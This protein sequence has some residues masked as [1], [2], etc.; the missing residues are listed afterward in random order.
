MKMKKVYLYGAI[1]LLLIGAAIFFAAFNTD[2]KTYDYAK[3]APGLVTTVDY[4]PIDISSITLPV[5]ATDEDIQHKIAS[6]LASKAS[7][8]ISTTIIPDNYD[9]VSV[10]YYGTD[11]DGKIVT[12]PDTMNPSKPTKVQLG[13]GSKW[14]AVFGDAITQKPK[15]YNTV[16]SGLPDATDI[17]FVTYTVKATD[18]EAEKKVTSE[19]YQ[20]AADAVAKFGDTILSTPIGQEIT[21]GDAYSSVKVDWVART[22]YNS[23]HAHAAG[24][25]MFITVTAKNSSDQTLTYYLHTDGTAENTTVVKKSGTSEDLDSGVLAAILAKTGLKTGDS[26][27]IES[28]AYTGAEILANDT[29]KAGT[30]YND[31]ACK[32]AIE[33]NSTLVPETTYYVKV[34]KHTY[35]VNSVMP[36]DP[37]AD[38][39]N[40]VK[41]ADFTDVTYT[42]PEDSTEKDKDGVELKGKTVTY[43]VIPVGVYNVDLSYTNISGLSAFTDR[44]DASNLKS[45]KT[46]YDTYAT[47]LDALKALS[48]VEV[49]KKAYTA[50]E[51]A[52]KALTKDTG[53]KEEDTTDFL[54]AMTAY[55]QDTDSAEKEAA[56]NQA[57]NDLASRLGDSNKSKLT[58]CKSTYTTLL[59]LVKEAGWSDLENSVKDAALVKGALKDEDITAFC[60]A[61]LAYFPDEQNKKKEI[62][63]YEAYTKF[64]AKLSSE[65]KTKLTEYVSALKTLVTRMR[66][67]DVISASLTTLRHYFTEAELEDLLTKLKA[68]VADEK[69]E[70]LKT[71]YEDA[72]KALED[73]ATDDADLSDADKDKQKAAL[74]SYTDACI[75]AIK[76]GQEAKVDAN[77]LLTAVVADV[78][79]QK[80]DWFTA[81]AKEELN[82]SVR[83]LLNKER[84]TEY[85][86]EVT[87][88]IW[89]YLLSDEHTT[90]KLPSRA[91][92]MAREEIT[93]FYKQ[94]YYED[95]K[96]YTQYKSFGEYLKATLSKEL[97]DGDTKVTVNSY[98]EAK[99]I[100]RQK[101]ETNVRQLLVIYAL[102]EKLGVNT[103][104]EEI[105]TYAQNGKTYYYYTEEQ[106]RNAYTMDK[107]TEIIMKDRGA[108]NDLY[109]E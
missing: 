41:A 65:N 42:Y 19:M 104:A 44:A 101:A 31:A 108:V 99:K 109:F 74:T 57:Y 54:A 4:T 80:S 93:D 27:N 50:Y 5:A 67:Y 95:E 17:L 25:Y 46:A 98:S 90:L 78:A 14:L 6:L 48:G 29:L 58:T 37:S 72:L 77:V 105:Q 35:T 87:K 69:N 79:E 62:A 52:V 2:G 82:T 28:I 9:I 11:A 51:N 64:S 66:G 97:S 106:R 23:K 60:E 21:A 89:S 84:Q 10:V 39:E 12:S 33:D 49:A 102:A 94:K 63:Y 86:A 13:S 30:V 100:I 53:I 56:Y 1:A 16:T 88:T 76:A 107:V 70:E 24:E 3:K 34:I 103:E 73:K 55:L 7:S 15:S 59:G 8:T 85:E 75:K 26:G 40:I 96:N 71:A 45:A 18:T 61:A 43:H 22:A 47:K 68:H 32:N 83:N 38:D 81:K 92:R 91:V 20:S 36:T